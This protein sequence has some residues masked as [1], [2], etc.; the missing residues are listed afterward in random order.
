MSKTKKKKTKIAIFHC[1]FIYSGG[2]ERIVLE[3]A[4]GLKKRGYD[5]LVYAPTLDAQKCFPELVGKVEVKTFFP[6]FIDWLPFRYGLRMVASSLLAPF[7]AFKFRDVDVFLGANQ[8]SAWFAYC[9]SRVLRK[10]YLVYLNQPNRLLYP[11]P[12]DKEFGWYSTVS[13]YQLLYQIIQLIKPIISFLD[14]VSITNASKLFVNGS[15]IGAAI[16]NVYATQTVDAPAG[17]HFRPLDSLS[18]N[19]HTSYKGFIKSGKEKISKPYILITNRHDPQKR[20]DY[21]IRALKEVLKQYRSVSLVI[22]G[23]FT[24]HTKELIELAKKLKIRDKV[25]FLGQISESELQKLY[26]HAAVYCYPAPEEDFGLG[27]LEAGSWGVVTV[28]WK[29]GGP[30][31]TVEDGVTGFLAQP[32]DVKDF[33]HKILTLLNSPK[34]R[35]KMGK[36]ARKRTKEKFSWDNHVD[37]IEKSINVVLTQNNY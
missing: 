8:P 15:Y 13:D 22:P 34:L 3:E 17:A 35:A 2:G 4:R 25:F 24:E 33:A 5:V 31:V 11:R 7:L 14:K 20:F 23:P 28:A 16:E 9:I 21:V 19:P 37:I 18:I 29:H 36:A 30:T 27:P 26:K 10:P 12:V 32:Y 1:G 6:S